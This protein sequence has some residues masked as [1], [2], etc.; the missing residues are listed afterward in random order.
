M[1]QW[2]FPTPLTEVT[3]LTDVFVQQI[4]TDCCK[5]DDKTDVAYSWKTVPV[6]GGGS[7]QLIAAFRQHGKAEECCIVV[8]G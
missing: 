6:A 8:T 1:A 7:M 5:L 4:V 3:Q 2:H